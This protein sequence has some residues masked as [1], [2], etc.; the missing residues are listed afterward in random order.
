MRRWLPVGLALALTSASASA[1]AAS[2]APK[3]SSKAATPEGPAPPA[4]PAPKASPA[5]TPE[6]PASPAPKASPAPTPE[7]P[8]S[9]APKASSKP[10]PE[11]PASPA[12]KASSKPTPE[13]P[14]L[15]PDPGGAR[16]ET[17]RPWLAEA[18]PGDPE[19]SRGGLGLTRQRDGS[20]LFVDPGKR[21]T[22]AVNRDGS[23]RFGDRWGR[24]QHGKRMRGSGAALR[25]FGPSGIGGVGMAV[26]GPTEWLLA[27]SG[28]E[29]DA[30]AKT[31]FLNQTRELRIQIA[32]A[33]TRQ[34]LET[35]LGELGQELLGLGADASR[36]LAER[37]ALLFQ[38]WDECDERMLAGLP[39]GG[40]ELPA[41]AVSAIDEARL[42]AAEKARRTIEGFIRRQLPRGSARAY[43]ADELK[44]LN[45]RRVSVEPFAPYEARAARP[46]SPVPRDM[47]SG[48]AQP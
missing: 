7:G 3:A 2:P 48:A 35:R 31:A 30:A 13:G 24:D 14:A 19:S 4:S 36:S 25:T 44:E 28:Q 27:L 41:E 9:P 10:T 37:R 21:F 46:S 47:S 23:V 12:P 5:P 22:A 29:F 11:G 39:T 16:I 38:R 32:V 20:V 17:A 45:R 33:F 43:T 26:T 8:A 40:S 1:S 6:G 15:P 42:A 34:L 18:P